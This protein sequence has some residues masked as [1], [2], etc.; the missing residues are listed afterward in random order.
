MSSR[1]VLTAAAFVSLAAFTTGCPKK[2]AAGGDGGDADG[3]P[4]VGLDAPGNDPAYVAAAKGLMESCAAK[5][6]AK[7]GFE[8]C[9]DPLRAF[10]EKKFEG[11]D[12]TLLNTL[13][14]EDIKARWIGAYSLGSWGSA[15]KTDKALATRLFGILEKEKPGSIVDAQ[16]AYAAGSAYES[17]GLAERLKTYGLKATTPLDVKEV[18]AAWSRSS[19]EGG[20]EITKQ[21]AVMPDKKAVRA[22]AQGYASHFTKHEDEACKFW[23]THLEDDDKAVRASVVGHITGGW[24]GNT[25][26]DADGDWYITGGGGGPSSGDTSWCKPADIDDALAK[27]T[28]RA[29]A[30]TIDESNYIYGLSNLV[31][32]KK[33]TDAQ[34][35]LAVAAL[36]KVVETKG[37]H[38]R[39][40]ALRKLVDAKPDEKAYAMRFLKD[41]DLKLTAADVTKPAPPPA[42]K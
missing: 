39:S 10:R 8:D 28:K 36:K 13:D 23:S 37:S 42:K 14:D 3:K 19:D 11:I 24:S 29:A 5:W 27:I 30:N 31:K 1:A 2:G 12:T 41:D 38:E 17:A 22:A 18:L 26:H 4:K 16:L 34:K 15:F 9:S 25:T 40:F 6:D 32:Q 20:Y 21:L 33:T 35:K 7:K